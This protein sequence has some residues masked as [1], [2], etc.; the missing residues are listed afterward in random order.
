[1]TGF[2]PLIAF[3]G[4]L[5]NVGDRRT[6]VL[7]LN[8]GAPDI[9]NISG[10]SFNFQRTVTFVKGIGGL[11]NVSSIFGGENGDLLFLGGR[12]VKLLNG[13]GNL[14]LQNNYT[15]QPG[16]TMILYFTGGAWNE[17]NRSP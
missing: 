17:L 6:E 1:M 12:D 14:V 11:V 3:A 2:Q 15:L 13:V 10:P 7:K 5:E 4:Q 8:V 9:Q 16:K